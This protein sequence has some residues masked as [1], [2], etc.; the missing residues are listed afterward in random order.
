LPSGPGSNP[1]GPMPALRAIL[2]VLTIS[3]FVLVGVPL[4]WLAHRMGSPL[5]RRMPGLFHRA[6]C[7]VLRLRVR[8]SGEPSPD[9]PQLLVPNHVSWIDILAIGASGP[10]CFL[11]KHE[12]ARWPVIGAL[13][14]LQGVVFVDRSRRRRLPQVNAEIARHMVAGDPVV[15]FA[16]ATTGDGNRLLKFHSPHF[17]AARLAMQAAGRQPVIQPLAIVYTRRDGLPLGRAGRAAIAWYGDMTL[18]GHL[19]A[20][21]KGGPVDCD[22]IYGHPI[23][24]SPQINRKIAARATRAAVRNLV[25]EALTGRARIASEAPELTVLI[26]AEKT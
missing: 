26:G 16:E 12:V 14:R 25:V 18:A 19:W 2:L 21:L 5:A 23:P 6:L 17:E 15:L 24:F 7:A 11:A 8:Y 10:V 22:V 3:A 20:L 9:R 1:T 13:A 4:H